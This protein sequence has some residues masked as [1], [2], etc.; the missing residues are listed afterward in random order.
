MI[1]EWPPM[2]ARKIAVVC[3]VLESFGNGPNRTSSSPF[4]SG[5]GIG[6]RAHD[7]NVFSEDDLQNWRRR[8]FK[9]AAAAVGLS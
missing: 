9:P 7:G 6:P 3:C 4:P 5:E 2:A 1:G 8:V